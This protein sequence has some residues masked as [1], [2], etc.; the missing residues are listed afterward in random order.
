MAE[1][2]GEDGDG[3]GGEW[4]G[5]GGEKELG[6]GGGAADLGV[7]GAVEIGA[8][9]V[10]RVAGEE[11]RGG[12]E[13]GVEGD[14]HTVAG[15]GWDD[16][17]LVA[18]APEGV[19]AGVAG[20]GGVVGVA[21]EEAVGDAGEGE[22]FGKEGGGGGDAVAEKRGVRGD[23]AEEVGP[24]CAELSVAGPVDDEAEIG[25]G[26]VGM[27][28]GLDGLEAGIAAGEEV[29]LDVAVEGG[30]LGGGEGEVLLE[31]E[32]V[33]LAAGGTGEGAE[34]VFA[35]GEE[36]LGGGEGLAGGEVGLPSGCGG[37]G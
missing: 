31:G 16:G 36:G 17:G 27:G 33:V 7:E 26:L 15:K 11:V 19:G 18:K 14:G 28:V 2:G 32:E 29:E 4:L 34:V 35:G 5:V 9:V 10:G 3:E 22:G 8:E 12:E 23:V 6:D 24:A 30:G 1:E 37:C 13:G 20:E 25:A 21:E